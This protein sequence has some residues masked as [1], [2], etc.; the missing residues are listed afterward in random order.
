MPRLKGQRGKS[1][2]PELIYDKLEQYLIE[3]PKGS[4]CSVWDSAIYCGISWRKLID[5]GKEFED[6]QEFIDEIHDR[7]MSYIDSGCIG[8]SIPG[9][10]GIFAMKNLGLKDQQD[11]NLGG[12]PGNPIENKSIDNLT[13]EQILAIRE[14]MRGTND[15]K[16]D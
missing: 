15:N 1:C 5:L 2:N 11:I 16:T 4:L 10:Y 8:D 13:P 14:A 3:H 6:I 12:Q 9:N 7:R